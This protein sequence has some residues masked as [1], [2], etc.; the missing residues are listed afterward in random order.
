MI[1]LLTYTSRTPHNC[2][3]KVFC[4]VQIIK[5]NHA[6]ISVFSTRYLR[7]HFNP[8]KAQSALSTSVNSSQ[9]KYSS[10]HLLFTFA[11]FV[12][13][14]GTVELCTIVRLAFTMFLCLHYQQE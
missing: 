14:R 13:G 5:Q 12:R 8:N 4:S 1:V 3:N 11:Q 9:G 10:V 6:S 2:E 7:Q